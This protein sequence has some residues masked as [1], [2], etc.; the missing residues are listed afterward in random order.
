[1]A[2]GAAKDKGSGAS[3]ASQKVSAKRALQKYIAS[4]N[5]MDET[6]ETGI[7]KRPPCQ[8]YDKLIC[9]TEYSTIESQIMKC[10]TADALSQ[11]GKQWAPYK[12]ALAE[13]LGSVAAGAKAVTSRIE[14][15]K[16]AK[17]E[18]AKRKAG[19]SASKPGKAAK[20][21]H[22]RLFEDALDIGA[23]DM[24]TVAL[25]DM[26]KVLQGVDNFSQ[27]PRVF[28]LDP[29][30][31]LIEKRKLL[32]HASAFGNKFAASPER[33]DKGFR[34]SLSRRAEC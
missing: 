18:A 14:A 23:Q 9:L 10:T 7:G 21:D 5:G 32:D 8:S 26:Y 19:S 28:T 13:L 1:M 24:P 31:P 16:K 27:G 30:S 2:G 17:E 15:V 6:R 20:F 12:K 11:V 29:R 33:A 3:S 4:F 34:N 22:F 25:T